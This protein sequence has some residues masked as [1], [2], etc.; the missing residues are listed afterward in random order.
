MRVKYLMGFTLIELMITVVIV[1]IIATFAYPSYQNSVRKS[2][3]SD[4][5]IALIDYASRLERCF[6]RS[7]PNSYTDASCP[8]AG[9]SN[10]SYYNIT[11]T[12]RT[13]TTYTIQAVPT[14]KGNQNKDINC[15]SFTL[16]QLGVKT[17]N[18]ATS[19]CW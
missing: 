9:S 11:Y 8:L 10:E 4:A 1:A 5:K 18:P 19:D 13:L 7:S 2:R 6:S 3:R 17:P 14:S 16:N 12:A 15:T